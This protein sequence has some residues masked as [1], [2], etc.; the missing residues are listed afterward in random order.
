MVQQCVGMC[1]LVMDQHTMYIHTQIDGT[2]AWHAKDYPQELALACLNQSRQSARSGLKPTDAGEAIA[3]GWIFVHPS[4]VLH[5][6]F[7][8]I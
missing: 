1:V 5:T 4:E 3:R 6:H 8:I 2:G 7:G